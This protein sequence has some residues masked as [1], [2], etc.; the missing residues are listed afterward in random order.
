MTLQA[1]TAPCPK[2]EA[3][4]IKMRTSRQDRLR[5]RQLDEGFHPYLSTKRLRRAS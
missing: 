3:L 5:R 1:R 4:V 2:P